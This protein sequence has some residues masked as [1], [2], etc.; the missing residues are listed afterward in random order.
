MSNVGGVG[1]GLTSCA[2]LTFS[3][4]AMIPMLICGSTK[5]A[6]SASAARLCKRSG[7]RRATYARFTTPALRSAATMSL[8]RPVRFARSYDQLEPEGQEDQN[9]QPETVM[10]CERH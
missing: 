5:R 6:G 3:D 7:A 10:T 1:A 8:G 4:R 2:S 9:P